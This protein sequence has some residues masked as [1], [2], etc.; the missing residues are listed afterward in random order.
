MLR[1]DSVTLAQTIGSDS[2]LEAFLDLTI[3]SNGGGWGGQGKLVGVH[4]IGTSWTETGGFPPGTPLIFAGAADSTVFTNG[5]Q[6]VVTYIVTASIRNILESS[7]GDYVQGFMVR[8]A[9]ES[10]PASVTF[11]SRESGNPP[12]LRLIVQRQTPQVPTVAPDTVPAGMFAQSNWRSGSPC[13]SGNM[14][15][16]VLVVRFKTGTAQ[17]QKQAAI[18]LIDG[19]VIGGLPPVYGEGAYYVRVEYDEAGAILCDAVATLKGLPQVGVA[20]PVHFAVGLHRRP[21]DSEG[22]QKGDWELDPLFADGGKH[23]LERIAAPLAWGCETGSDQVPVAVID[24][25]F[26]N[27]PD[28]LSN[29]A[30][31]WR[32]DIGLNLDTIGHGTEVASVLG[33]GGDNGIGITGTMWNADLRPYDVQ[34]L[35]GSIPMG[36]SP[37]EIVGMA[38]QRAALDGAR[39]VN[40]SMGIWWQEQFERSPGRN[41]IASVKIVQRPGIFT[42][43]CEIS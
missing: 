6:G 38:V 30:A 2:L 39:I 34:Y 4:K 41:R 22:W 35:G 27:V 10:G 23:G 1:W 15:R 18:D 24:R 17:A 43:I 3:E 13:M 16:D 26:E 5:Q 29:I 28:V 20:G 25:G 40:L 9:Q 8:L 21:N 36:M 7:P 12:R 32:G 11:G 19:E 37:S 33:A 31:Q 14:L 42:I